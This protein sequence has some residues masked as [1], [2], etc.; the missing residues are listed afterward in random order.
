MKPVNVSNLIPSGTVMNTDLASAPQQVY[1]A[2]ILCVQLVWTG[3]PTG[4]F[5][6]QGSCDP[7]YSG[8]P[9]SGSSGLNA[10]PVNWSDLGTPYTTAVSSAGNA[11]YNYPYPG[12]N[13]VRVVYT[14]GSSG[15]ATSVVTVSTCNIKGF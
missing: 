13:W 1:N 11:I 7:A 10:N 6:L 2:F 14:D 12:F 3:T 8:I 5:K 15:M 9:T 4:T